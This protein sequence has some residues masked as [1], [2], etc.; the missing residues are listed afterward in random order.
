MD[1]TGNIAWMGP[2]A[3]LEHWLHQND[4]SIEPAMAICFVVGSEVIIPLGLR[5]KRNL[6]DPWMSVALEM[7]NTGG[8]RVIAA[9]RE[10]FLS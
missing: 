6:R 8:G 5:V 3:T 1:N 10:V 2:L 4:L 7:T 9:N